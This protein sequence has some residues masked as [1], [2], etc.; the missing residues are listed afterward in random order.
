M[1]LAG[2]FRSLRSEMGRPPSITEEEILAAAR[3]VFLEKGIAGTT[4]AVAARCGVSEATVFRRFSTKDE[5]FRMALLTSFPDWFH[6]MSEL[7]GQG[8][9]REVLLELG[10]KALA[11]FRQMLP[12]A[13]MLMS[14]P[15]VA[16]FKRRA[17]VRK[18]V[19]KSLG[20]YFAAEIGAGR[21][22][23]LDPQFATRIFVGGLMTTVLGEWPD[24]PFKSDP[25]A[26]EAFLERLVELLCGPPKKGRR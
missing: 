13:A 24:D 3:A 15:S 20:D 4:A 1:T 22:R 23:P 12:A 8:D 11:F 21:M 10:R 5:L 18:N 9:P 17:L 7:A 25:E 14:N 2:S 16:F 6:S 26:E 19:L